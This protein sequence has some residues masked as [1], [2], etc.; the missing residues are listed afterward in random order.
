M[1]R[2]TKI[3]LVVLL[4]LAALAI[5]NSKAGSA[6]AWDEKG[7]LVSGYG[8]PVQEAK[9]RALEIAHKRYGSNV[10]IL[11]ASDV[12]GYGAN[13]VASKGTGSV[14]GVSLGRPSAA[15]AERRAIQQCLMSGGNNPKVRWRFR[16]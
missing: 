2:G 16:G 9:R 3:R 4:C 5:H 14:V 12:T 8:V 1:K 15:D 10:S 11:A 13:A 6:V 7:H